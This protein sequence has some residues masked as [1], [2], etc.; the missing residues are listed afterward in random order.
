MKAIS[1]QANSVLIWRYLIRVKFYLNL[2]S[3]P[4]QGAAAQDVLSQSDIWSH[5]GPGMRQDCDLLD[6]NNTTCHSR[7]YLQ[8]QNS[9][10]K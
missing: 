7:L 3:D 4:S 8:N 9:D 2:R 6:A 5:T 1:D 10:K